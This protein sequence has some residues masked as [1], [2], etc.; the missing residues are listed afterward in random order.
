MINQSY[1]HGVM[2]KRN[3]ITKV[4]SEINFF[5]SDFTFYITTY[6]ILRKQSD[7]CDHCGARNGVRPELQK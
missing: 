7:C 3:T 4:K 2:H 5:K 6:R 1:S